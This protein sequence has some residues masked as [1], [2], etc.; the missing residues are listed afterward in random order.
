[1]KFPRIIRKK[2]FIEHFQSEIW[3]DAAREICAKHR[4][5]FANLKRADSSDHIVFFIDDKLVLKIYTPVRNCFEREVKAINFVSGKTDF[6]TP[7]IVQ[8]GK[9]EDLDYVLMTTLPEILMTRADWLT[10]SEKEQ[11]SFISKL[12]VG[13]KQVHSLSAESFKDDWSAFVEDR[14]ATFIE[15]QVEH[16]V[17]KKVLDALPDFIEENLKFIPTNS[18]TVFM[19]GDVHF[20]NLRVAKEL[21]KWQISGLFDFADSRRGFHEYEFL[22]VGLLMMQ[23]QREVQREFFRAY[24]YEEKDLDETLRKRLMM[25]TMLYET[26]DLRRYAMRLKPEA[27]DFTL[28]ELERG[29]WSFAG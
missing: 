24:G 17:N 15:R 19:H 14:A 7:E 9:I 11:K 5:S 8:T 18:Q 1:M 16:G 22:A 27:I 21:G 28:D 26:A 23:G 3:F 13:L 20:G 29:I 25:L 2:D 6:R 4:I 10:L 12:A